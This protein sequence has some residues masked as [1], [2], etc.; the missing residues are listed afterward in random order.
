VPAGSGCPD[1][2]VSPVPVRPR[3]EVED[4][5]AS[6]Q[7]RLAVWQAKI[8]ATRPPRT[9]EV[10]SSTEFSQEFGTFEGL[11]SVEVF[12]SPEVFGSSISGRKSEVLL[13]SNV[14]AVNLDP[15]LQVCFYPST[16]TKPT[17]FSNGSPPFASA[18]RP[19]LTVAYESPKVADLTKYNPNG[20]AP[21]VNAKIGIKRR[22][23]PNMKKGLTPNSLFKSKKILQLPPTVRVCGIQLESIESDCFWSSG[24]NKN[25]DANFNYEPNFDLEMEAPSENSQDI[26]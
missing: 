22:I 13:E 15:R 6:H 4:R 23:D 16:I 11:S 9:S 10:C 3:P 20:K 17:T 21:A 25:W 1:R 14:S 12:R 2:E 19:L 24:R 26:Q 5:L 18:F 8:R 7:R